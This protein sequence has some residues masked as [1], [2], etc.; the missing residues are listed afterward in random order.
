MIS[1]RLNLNFLLLFQA[2]NHFFILVVNL[3][4][5]ELVGRKRIFSKRGDNWSSFPPA[6]SSLKLFF[7]VRKQE[8]LD[9]EPECGVARHR[10]FSKR[11]IGG[12]K[13]KFS[14]LPW[15]AH[16][17]ISSYQCGGVLLNHWWV[18]TNDLTIE[19]QNLNP[20]SHPS[21]TLAPQSKGQWWKFELC[22]TSATSKASK[23]KLW[24]FKLL[25]L[26]S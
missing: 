19:W 7:F 1:L 14:E 21:A 2:V 6:L 4:M 3:Q 15:Q 23:T 9:H 26:I 17:R 16:I 12:E 18:T 24:N 8:F 22:D 13:A 25:S 20:L 5:S 10:Q 11:I